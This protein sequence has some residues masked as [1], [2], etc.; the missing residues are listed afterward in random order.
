MLAARCC[1]CVAVWCC[2]FCYCHHVHCWL[3]VTFLLVSLLDPSF[4]FSV[5]D[6]CHYHCHC[7][8]LQHLP[9]VDYCYPRYFYHSPTQQLLSPIVHGNGCCQN[10]FYNLM[11]RVCWSIIWKSNI[12]F[13]AIN[14][15]W[16]EL[17]Y[18][19]FRIG[20]LIVIVFIIYLLLPGFPMFFYIVP[21]SRLGWPA[22]V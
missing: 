21:T 5:A 20:D 14:A 22:N 11:W 18:H 17:W 4:V 3:I 10:P 8:C 1:C 9:P 12:C 16:Y 13:F 7:H 2:C 19:I 15:I 6:C